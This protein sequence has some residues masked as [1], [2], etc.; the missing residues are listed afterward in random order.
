M[1]TWVNTHGAF[2]TGIVYILIDTIGNILIV[3]QRENNL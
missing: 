1:I 2:V 3:D